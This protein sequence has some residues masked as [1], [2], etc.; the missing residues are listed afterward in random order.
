MP[1]ERPETCLNLRAVFAEQKLLH[2]LAKEPR[3]ISTASSTAIKQKLFEK[4][5]TLQGFAAAEEQ[6]HKAY[7]FS[8]TI[9]EFPAHGSQQVALP[10]AVK[11]TASL[12]GKRKDSMNHLTSKKP[13]LSGG[14][15]TMPTNL[16]FEAVE[17]LM[18]SNV[19]VTS[20]E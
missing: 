14:S 10:G 13:R 5:S 11:E 12:L 15:H 19:M 7:S 18:Q 9:A 6:L 3:S 4:K 1:Y 17:K 2:R 8:S 16:A 20:E